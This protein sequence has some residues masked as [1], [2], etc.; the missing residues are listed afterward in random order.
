M[1]KITNTQVLE[2]STTKT[3]QPNEDMMQEIAHILQKHQ[4]LQRFGLVCIDDNYNSKQV[5]NEN[6]IL[7]QRW[8]V[9]TPKTPQS[10]D[11]KQVL[12]TQWR[13]DVPG[14]LK[15]CASTCETTPDGPHNVY[16]HK[17]QAQ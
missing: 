10:I 6:C 1:Q 3:P 5:M 13:L 17:E 2:Y 4:A 14:M 16:T 15:A 12:E 7:P 8:L 11:P 9:T